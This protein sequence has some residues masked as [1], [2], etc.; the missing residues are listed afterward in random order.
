MA[1]AAQPGAAKSDNKVA[2]SETTPA[3]DRDGDQ[4][5]KFI[6]VALKYGEMTNAIIAK[7]K[8]QHYQNAKNKDL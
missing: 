2:N 8:K 6:A 5:S 3:K 7:L 4:Q 1:T